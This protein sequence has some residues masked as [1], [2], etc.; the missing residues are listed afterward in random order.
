[1]VRSRQGRRGMKRGTEKCRQRIRG[2][3]KVVGVVVWSAE[4]CGV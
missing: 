3:E 1:M 2:G 4:A